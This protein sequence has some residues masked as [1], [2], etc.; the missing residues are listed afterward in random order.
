[1]AAADFLVR[2][3]MHPV[4]AAQSMGVVGKDL[5]KAESVASATTPA[6]TPAMEDL[7][8]ADRDMAVVVVEV[9][10]V[11]EVVASGLRDITAVVVDLLTTVLINL[12]QQQLVT[13]MDK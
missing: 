10:T 5:Y 3:V 6:A 9:A 8:V 1:V 12:I 13:V 4:S 2:A 7:E 11:V